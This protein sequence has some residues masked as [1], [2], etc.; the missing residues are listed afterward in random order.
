MPER[1]PA[2]EVEHGEVEKKKQI[3]INHSSEGIRHSTKS[4]GQVP[5]QTKGQEVEEGQESIR[6]RKKKTR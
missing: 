4:V 5:G 3:N 2:A 1:V 6:E